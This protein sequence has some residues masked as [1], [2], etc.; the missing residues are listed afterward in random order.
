MMI[1]PHMLWQGSPA[2]FERLRAHNGFLLSAQWNGT[3]VVEP[4]TIA[5]L[6]GRRLSLSNPW[7]GQGMT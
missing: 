6:L 7:T 3:A 1:E 2:S 5:S 4:V